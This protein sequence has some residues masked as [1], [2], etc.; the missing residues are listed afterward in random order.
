[1]RA[2]LGGDYEAIRWQA[3]APGIRQAQRPGDGDHRTVVGAERRRGIEN[4][5]APGAEGVGQAR[6]QG[7]QSLLA[8]L[9][10]LVGQRELGVAG[11]NDVHPFEVE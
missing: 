1:M 10:G 9:V 5:A 11:N 8:G 3:M 2:L 7:R 6:P 4:M